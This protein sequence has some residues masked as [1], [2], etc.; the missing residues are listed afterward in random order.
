MRNKA[1]PDKV[2][3]ALSVNDVHRM[4]LFVQ[5]LVQIDRRVNP[6]KKAQKKSSVAKASASVKTTADKKADKSAKKT[7]I[8]SITK[9]PQ[10]REPFLLY[11]AFA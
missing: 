10:F 4:T 5:V 9:G 3:V 6:R 2:H 1:R 11:N 7:S 8:T